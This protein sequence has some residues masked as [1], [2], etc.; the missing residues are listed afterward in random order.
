MCGIVGIWDTRGAVDRALIERMR[1]CVRH[2]GPDDAGAYVDA[3]A[4]VALGHRRLSI[5]DPSPAGHQPMRA[6]DL[7]TVHNGEMYN[8][9]EVREAL[10]AEGDHFETETDTEVILAGYRRWG[11]AV[12]ERFHGMFAT[13]LWDGTAREMVVIRDRPG[14][15][16]LY[17][18]HRD[19]LFAFA[20]EL[21]ALL[22]H[23]DVPRD[24]D[25][26]ALSLFLKHGF[27]PAPHSIFSGIRK[28]PAG[29]HL[30]LDARGS[31]T[32]A[33]YW[34]VIDVFADAGAADAARSEQEA[35]DEL[36][37]VLTR[38]FNLRM[39]S[40]V[41]VGVFLSGGIDSSTV[42]ALLQKDRTVP[43]KTF[44]IGFPSKDYN[45]AEAAKAVAAHLGTEHHELYCDAKVAL[46]I[47]PRLPE[48]YDEPFGDASGIP[49]YLLASFASEQVKVALSA[50]GGDEL[51]AGYRHHQNL[52]RS[53]Q[54]Y[55]RFGSTMRFGTWALGQFPLRQLAGATIDNL[56]LKIKKLSEITRKGATLS[57]FLFVGRSFWPEEDVRSLLGER[58]GGFDGFMAP[59]R[60]A[61]S[62]IDGFTNFMRAADFTAYLADDILVKVDRATMAVGLEGRDPFLDQDVVAFAA[63]LPVEYLNREGQGKRIVKNILYKYVPRELVDRPKQGFAVPLDIWLRKEL[64]HLVTDY[65]GEDAIR[66]GGIFAWPAVQS[67]IDG[68]FSGRMTSSQRL[69]LL[70]EFEMWR[71]KWL[72]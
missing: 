52:E 39:V 27:V 29:H 35:T 23:P 47:I 49:T 54:I 63:T 34:N 44:T 22:A 19:G 4:G 56:D 59:F 16:P 17:Y 72:G 58:A 36:E 43:V 41:P 64:R 30:R 46:D 15:K 37:R 20:S 21:R 1:E 70:L 8:F 33:P 6:G 68:F 7:W 25:F 9:K 10:V 61:E 5:L 45:E 11:T 28:L 26:D 69:W 31:L 50:D 55:S 42:T 53:F 40:D 65:L 57:D 71:R 24:I 14:V 12:F 38:S 51:F 60:S 67:E 13:A 2:R 66:S 48:I 32:V 3:G 62:R 18:Y